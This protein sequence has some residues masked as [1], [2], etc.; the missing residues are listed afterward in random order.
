MKKSHIAILV[1]LAGIIWFI[2][3]NKIVPTQ[4]SD[5]YLNAVIDSNLFIS[6][7]AS[8]SCVRSGDQLI[9]SSTDPENV[10]LVM[11]I[12]N[13][14]GFDSKIYMDGYVAFAYFDSGKGPVN[15]LTNNTGFI[16]ITQAFPYIKGTFFFQTTDSSHVTHGRFNVVAPQ[17]Q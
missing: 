17:A 8:V 14:N 9:F 15:S 3:C 16:N 5:N 12:N 11:C 1:V 2:S 7:G 4:V 6:T 10:K 13:F